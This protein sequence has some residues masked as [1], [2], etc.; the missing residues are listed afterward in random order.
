MTQ[1]LNQ[2]LP[3]MINHQQMGWYDDDGKFHFRRIYRPT[4]VPAG[5]CPMDFGVEEKPDILC[6]WFGYTPNQ[7]MELRRIYLK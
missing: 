4:R 3:R 2:H 7:A 5:D 6:E 1:H